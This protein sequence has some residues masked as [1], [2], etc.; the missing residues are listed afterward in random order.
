MFNQITSITDPLN[1]TTTFAYDALGRLTAITDPLSHRITFTYNVAG[2][3]VSITNAANETV[4]LDYILGD[5]SK[6]T[7]GLGNSTTRF[8]DAAGRLV[9]VSDP[10]GHVVT[11]TVDAMNRVTMVTDSLGGRTSFSYDGNSNMLTLV[12]PN[13][14][15]TTWSYDD[16]D[17]VDTRTDPLGRAE[18]Y[19]Y[20]ANGNLA[21][22]TDRK[23]QRTTF[24]HDS[25]DR[26]TVTTYVDASTV[27][28]TYDAGDRWTQVSDS[29]GGTITHTYDGLDRV[30]SE[31][32]P[33]GSL[34]FGYDRAGRRATMD[35][36]G[37]AEISYAYDD[38][39]RITTITQLGGVASFGYDAANRRTSL[40]LPN[41]IVTRYGYDAAS[42]L[43]SLNYE[44]SNTTLGDLSYTYDAASRRVQVGGS[45][46]R[47]SLPAALPSASY[48]AANEIQTFDGVQFGYDANGNVT[49]DGVNAYEWNARNQLAQVS[50]TGAASFVYDG[51]GR[52]RSRT[53]SGVASASLYDGPNVVQELSGGSPVANVVTSL[54][55]DE[56]LTRSDATGTAA[57]LADGL[58]STVAL[59]DSGGVVRTEYTYEPFGAT[60]VTG[61]GST[62]VAAFTG[63]ELDESGLYFYRARYYDP[64]RERFVSEDPLDVLGGMNLFT[65]VSDRPTQYV[66]PLGLKRQGSGKGRPGG[67]TIGPGGPTMGP[68]GAGGGAGTGGGG[69]GKPT[70]DSNKPDCNPPSCESYFFQCLA[71]WASPGW[72]TA[73]EGVASAGANARAI[74]L[75]GKALSHAAARGLPWPQHSSI[76]QELMGGAGEWAEVGGAVI[77]LAVIDAGILKCLYQEMSALANGTCR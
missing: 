48:D 67:P 40:T 39:N 74:S 47:T 14:H 16:M 49:S 5:L 24:V 30:T 57:L 64:G 17:R 33:E 3:P 9:S 43:T 58:G 62:N 41:G 28:R 54:R 45:W 20:D 19:N 60:T 76:W 53:I 36:S 11:Y 4:T 12:D 66:D 2:Q 15:S 37:Q 34:Q 10:L 61:T 35:V 50:G 27:A 65:Y 1:H 31:S 18:T 51:L 70:G 55:I 52:R 69:G 7:D 71:D 63:R 46:A 26:L 59:A 13:N 21:S 25:L 73:A 22:M 42:H 32:T 38:A 56:A 68:A 75:Y 23:N 77:P 8:V 44:L 6:I 29:T 72:N